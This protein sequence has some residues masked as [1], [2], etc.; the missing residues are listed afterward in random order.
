MSNLRFVIQEE[1]EETKNLSF[2]G[3]YTVK[4][5][6]KVYLDLIEIDKEWLRFGSPPNGFVSRKKSIKSVFLEESGN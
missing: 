5:L 1:G 6:E 2:A 3:K 4:D